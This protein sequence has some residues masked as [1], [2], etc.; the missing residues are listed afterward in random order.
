MA[1]LTRVARHRRPT[2]LGRQAAI[3][4]AVRL[5]AE[6]FLDRTTSW[7][8][9][10]PEV[11]AS[12]AR[13][14]GTSRVYLFENYREEDDEVWA[15]QR[16]EWSAPGVRSIADDPVLAALPMVE[17]GFGSLGRAVPS[18][19]AD[20]RPAAGAPRRR[21]RPSSRTTRRCR[22]SSSRSRS[23]AAG[24]ACSASTSAPSSACGPRPRSTRSARRPAPSPRRIQAGRDDAERTATRELLERRLAALSRISASLTVDSL[25]ADD[26]R[27]ALPGRRRDQRCGR[28]LRPARRGRRRARGRRHVRRARRVRRG[29]G[30]VAPQRCRHRVLAGGPRARTPSGSR[31]PRCGAAGPGLRAAA[32]VPARRRLGRAPGASAGRARPPH[33][34]GQRLVPARDRARTRASD[35][36]SAPSPTTPRPRSRTPASTRQRRTRPPCEERHRLARELHDS[37]SQA[38][39]G[40][41]LGARTARTLAERDGASVIEP[42]DYVLSLAEAGLAEMRALIFELR[43]EAIATEGLVAAIDRQ[44]S[45]LRARH[46]V[47]VT[48]DPPG[49]ARPAARSEGGPLPRQPG[50]PPQRRRSTPRPDTSTSSCEP[51]APGSSSAS[52]T[53]GSGSTPTAPTPAT[54]GCTRCASASPASAACWT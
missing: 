46:G 23:R 12:L 39:Y 29:A 54:W 20:P 14:T 42:L 17:A 45:A 22:S 18:G 48:T 9:H 37:V 44:A 53:T 36:S 1:P 28:R 47:A 51:T 31:R 40:I 49:R 3:L 10:A 41:A 50:G 26:A 7:E 24:G 19:R 13:A 6:R 52:S 5:G 15:T 30:G 43:P 21:S 32:P 35:A 4:E 38:L 11:L 16:F 2:R 33:R 34:L 25:A 27:R 8:D